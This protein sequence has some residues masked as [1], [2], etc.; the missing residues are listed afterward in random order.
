M[1]YRNPAS[2]SSLSIR[3]WQKSPG[4][5]ELETEGLEIWGDGDKAGLLLYSLSFL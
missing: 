1:V 3:F 4:F 5:L 2:G